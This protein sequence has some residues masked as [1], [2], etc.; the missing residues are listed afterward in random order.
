MPYENCGWATSHA[1][2]TMGSSKTDRASVTAATRTSPSRPLK[3]YRVE[4]TPEAHLHVRA[5]QA[6]WKANR[7]TVR[8]LFQQELR[9]ALSKLAGSPATVLPI[10]ARQASPVYGWFTE[11]FDTRDLLEAKALLEDLR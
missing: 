8:D 3:R 10:A 4:L 5:I 11:G 6:W 9:A 1:A 2:L 7:P